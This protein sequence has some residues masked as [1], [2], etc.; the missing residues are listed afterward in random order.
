MTDSVAPLAI[1]TR[2]AGP[3][4]TWGVATASFQIEGA[5]E[6]EIRA[7]VADI[8]LNAGQRPVLAIGVK[9]DGHGLAGAQGRAQQIV[10]I[11]PRSQS[12]CRDGFI[13]QDGRIG[14]PRLDLIPAEAR[15]RDDTAAG[16]RFEDWQGTFIVLSLNN[17]ERFGRRQVESAS[18]YV[19]LHLASRQFQTTK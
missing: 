14:H 11:G 6:A 1:P 10:R 13:D 19:I 18:R 4:F 9:T 2:F 7:A 3:A 8:N 16:H 5:T 12:A 15:F 17:D